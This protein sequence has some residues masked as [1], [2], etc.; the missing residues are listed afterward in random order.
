MGGLHSAKIIL[1]SVDFDPLEKR[2][3][4]GDWA[5]IAG[6]LTEA[7]LDLEKAGAD[8]LLICTNTMLNV[9]EEVQ[10]S[11]GI[12]ILH[13]AMKSRANRNTTTAT[14]PRRPM[15]VHRFP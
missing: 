6:H 5:G 10:V 2:L 9:A 8:F 3:Q 7:A 4:Q 13:M 11:T 14:A 15:A 12:S 1:Y